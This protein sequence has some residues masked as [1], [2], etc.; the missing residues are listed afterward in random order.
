M[1][2]QEKTGIWIPV[3]PKR[4]YFMDFES[5]YSSARRQIP[6]SYSQPPYP[7]KP[8]V[9]LE[10]EAGPPLDPEANWRLGVGLKGGDPT[11]NPKP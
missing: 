8:R 10:S 3:R 4:R 6:T 1:P 5:A 9:F 11:L 7:S 2:P